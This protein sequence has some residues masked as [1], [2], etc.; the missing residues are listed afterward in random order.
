M[1]HPRRRRYQLRNRELNRLLEELIERAQEVYGEHPDAEYLRQMMVSTLRLVRDQASRGDLKL[2]NNALKELRHAFRVFARY[3][4]VRKVAIFGSARTPPEH[5]E[6][7]Q[8]HAFAEKMVEAGWMV[9]TGAGDG[10]MGAAQGGAGRRNSFGVNI[11]LPFEQAANPV[12]A[13]DS[14][15]INFRFFF[16]RKVTFVKE[17]HAIALFPGGFGTHDEGFEALTLIQT[18]KSEILPVVFID[19]PKGRYWKDWEEYVR[20]HLH[21]RGLI[22]P[23]DLALF[24][25]TDSVDQAVAMIGNFYSNYHSSRYV[26][27]LLV[28]R[29]HR[30]PDPE[31]LAALNEEFADLVEGGTIA[32]GSP[33]PEEGDEAD[34]LARVTLRFHRRDMGRLRQF[35]DRLNTFVPEQAAPPRE[36]A[37]HEIVESTI[38]PE[39]ELAQE[40]E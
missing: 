23:N 34:H 26:G 3:R 36:A 19:A 29:V 33:L 31:Q 7:I 30:A 39:A 11:H 16:T 38:P 37:P 17:A 10:I 28:I 1:S 25:V 5:P 20:S 22:S 24:E 2:L 13:G 4:E 6:Y 40:E 18:G 8:A 27:D 14:K 12:I 9:I 21:A 15:L 35:I 32:T